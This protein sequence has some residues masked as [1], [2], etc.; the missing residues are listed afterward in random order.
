MAAIVPINT[1]N[2]IVR[3]TAPPVLMPPL[4]SVLAFATPPFTF[5]GEVVGGVVGVTVTV[6]TWPVTVSREMTGVGVH[7]GELDEVVDVVSTLAGVDVVAG[8]VDVGA[9]AADVDYKD[10]CQLKNRLVPGYFIYVESSKCFLKLIQGESI[11][12][13]SRSRNEEDRL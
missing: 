12:L 4:L 10:N 13:P 7:V 2:P 11:Q 6:R 9:A 5:W 8:V 3:P 1:T